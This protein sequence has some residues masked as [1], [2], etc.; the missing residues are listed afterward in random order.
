MKM[1]D[2][3][4]LKEYVNSSK[5]AEMLNISRSRVLR[6]CQQNRFENAIKFEW[7]WLIPKKAVKN[8]TRRKRGRKSLKTIKKNF[9]QSI[10]KEANEWKEKQVNT[11]T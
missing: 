3:Q 4:E 9:I 8:F 11:K 2:E 7:T 5:A 6:L 1:I 10:I